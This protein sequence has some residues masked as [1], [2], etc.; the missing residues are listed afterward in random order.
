M[1][2]RVMSVI[3][4]ALGVS[5]NLFLTILGLLLACTAAYW[6]VNLSRR[7]RM[8]ETQLRGLPSRKTGGE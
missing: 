2:A 4:I 7:V 6:G 5:G 8:L 3:A 1:P